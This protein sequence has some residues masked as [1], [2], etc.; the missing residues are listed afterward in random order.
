M[1]ILLKIKIKKGGGGGGP[2]SR[3]PL[4]PLQLTLPPFLLPLRPCRCRCR[5]RCDPCRSCCSHH[6]RC[7]SPR[8]CCTY[9]R[10]LRRC[11][12]AF[13]PFVY[14]H[15]RPRPLLPMVALGP[16]RSCT[17][18]V[19]ARACPCLSVL[20]CALMGPSASSAASPVCA[21]PAVRA[22][23]AVCLCPLVCLSFALGCAR[24][25]LSVLVSCSFASVSCLFAL[26]RVCLGSFVCLKYTVSTHHNWETHHCNM[27]YQP[28]QGHLISFSYVELQLTVF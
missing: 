18:F 20:V 9:T 27:H 19:L 6:L 3:P 12:P 23:P 25:C 21:R 17:S 26:V 7:C 28:R 15:T 8:W 1:E 4:P 5:S 14:P 16:A 2:Y 22:C 13:P 10:P 11:V 24:L